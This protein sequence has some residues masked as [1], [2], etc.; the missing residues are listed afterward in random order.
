MALGDGLQRDGGVGGGERGGG[1]EREC[2]GEVVIVC[3]GEVRFLRCTIGERAINTP[4][5]LTINARSA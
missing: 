3:V 1:G 5:Y 2:R 4:S